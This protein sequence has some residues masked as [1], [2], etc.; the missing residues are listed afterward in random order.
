MAYLASASLMGYYVYYHPISNIYRYFTYDNQ[1]ESKNNE[2]STKD[3]NNDEDI[4]ISFLSDDDKRNYNS[5][6]ESE[7]Y[8]NDLKKLRNLNSESNK[9]NENQLIKKINKLIENI[10][11]SENKDD[12]ILAKTIQLFLKSN[13]NNNFDNNELD[14]LIKK[15]IEY[16]KTNKSVSYSNIITGEI[17]NHLASK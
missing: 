14:I 6:V 16:N 3:E 10:D 1:V 8:I 2:D 7:T 9:N 12:I 11:E 4:F 17:L 15:Y 5:V 13:H